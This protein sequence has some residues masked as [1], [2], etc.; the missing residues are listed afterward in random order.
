MKKMNLCMRLCLWL[1]TVYAP[2]ISFAQTAPPSTFAEREKQFQDEKQLQEREKQLQSDLR[3]MRAEK[4]RS[5]EYFCKRETNTK[6]LGDFRDNWSAGTHLSTQVLK[7]DLAAK[8]ASSAENLGMGI[9]IR[10]YNEKVSDIKSECR[11]TTFDAKNVDEDPD[12]GKIR[13]ALFSIN[14]TVFY[15]KPQNSSDFNTQP[16]LVFSF[17]NDLVSFG[18]GFNMTGADK[19]HVF[20]LLSLGAGFNP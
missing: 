4:I 11:A 16:A 9:A 8:K 13:F 20:V 7:Y 5:R 10:Y 14:P 12:K 19:G 3:Q 2:A 17:L 6:L 15:S 18:L 1:V